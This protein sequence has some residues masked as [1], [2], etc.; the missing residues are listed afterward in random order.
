MSNFKILTKWNSILCKRDKEWVSY[1]VWPKDSKKD[2]PK[3]SFTILIWCKNGLL[4]LLKSI[5]MKSNL[6]TWSLFVRTKSMN[7]NAQ[8]FNL[9]I[10]LN[11]LLNSSQ[12][13]NQFHV[14]SIY[15]KRTSLFLKILLFYHWVN[16]S[17]QVFS[18]FTKLNTSNLSIKKIIDSI[19]QKLKSIYVYTSKAK[20]TL[21][22]MS[23]ENF[24]NKCLKNHW[25]NL[26]IW[27]KLLN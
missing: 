17:S 7:L 10:R 27:L 2:H 14:H 19:Y 15:P 12:I 16:K 21:E 4:N 1:L 8:K 26:L 13:L 11:S 9:F 24:L 22:K 5:W 23:Q 25:E 6:I 3:K 20:V 18:I